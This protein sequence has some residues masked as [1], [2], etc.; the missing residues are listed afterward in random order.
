MTLV[1]NCNENYCKSENF[2]ELRVSEDKHGL[3]LKI[4]WKLL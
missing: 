2:L 3:K 4:I 1:I